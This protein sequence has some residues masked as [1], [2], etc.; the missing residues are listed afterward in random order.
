MSQLTR[1][2]LKL[3]WTTGYQPT[4][5]DY[6]NMFD[7]FYNMLSV[8]DRNTLEGHFNTIYDAIGMAVTIM[9]NHNS[10]YNH[11]LIATALQS[12]IDPVF[13]TWLATDPIPDAQIQSDWN[14]SNNTLP[15]FIK[16]KPSI[17]YQYT[18]EQAQDAVGNILN[19]TG[20]VQFTYDDTTPKITANVDLSSKQPLDATLTALAGLDN[21]PGLIKQT[22]A[23]TF[24]KD[25]NTY[26]TSFTETDPLS[27]H[28]DQA[29]PQ[30]IVNGIPLLENTRVI[31]LDHEIVDKKFVDDKFN[32]LFPTYRVNNETEF[33]AAFTALNMAGGGNIFL[34]AIHFQV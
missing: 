31:D 9:S 29:T 14:Q 16:N 33:L 3:L 10:T 19:N 17:P 26:L 23:D 11:S 6:A 28:L 32:T 25:T 4:Q 15:D 18:D 22:G 8:E 34:I 20:N 5:T 12:E 30:T 13:Q 27:L 21:T 24:T 7:S 1:D 2:Q